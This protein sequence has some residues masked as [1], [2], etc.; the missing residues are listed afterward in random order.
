[1]S[2]FVGNE[3]QLVIDW[4]AQCNMSEKESIAMI[5]L[6]RKSKW[7]KLTKTIRRFLSKPATFSA[8]DVAQILNSGAPF[9]SDLYN[10]IVS[11]Q[12]EASLA[13]ETPAA[14]ISA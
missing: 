11:R 6:Y 10:L 8:S 13:Q 1:M 2:P 7:R 9:N 5:L 12:S 3:R 14:A 4:M